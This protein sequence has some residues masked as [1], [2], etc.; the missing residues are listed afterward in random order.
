MAE[1]K[2][3]LVDQLLPHLKESKKF[4]HII[5]GPRQVGKTTAARQIAALW[6]G[7]VISV[8][9]DG[10]LPPD[11]T[12][13]EAQWNRAVSQKNC[14]LII[15]EIQ[16]VHGWSETVKALWDEAQKS[17]NNTSVLLLGSSALLVQ[18]GL[19]ESLAGRFLLHR[20]DHWGYPEMHAAFGFTLDEWIFFGGYPG[21]A[22]FRNDVHLWAQYIRDSLIETVLA[23]DV[24]QMHTVAKP[25]L[26]RHLFM[27][28]AAYPAQIVSYNKMMGQLQDAGNTTTLA[29][30]LTLLESAFIISGLEQFKTDG[31]R[32][33]GSS[34]K[35]ILRNNALVSAILNITFEQAREDH[36]LWGRLVENAVGGFLSARFQGTPNEIFYWRHRD[37]EVD[38]VIREPRKMYAVEVQTSRFEPPHGM[39]A[40]RKVCPE[41]IP[42]YIGTGG[43]PFEEFF[44]GNFGGIFGGMREP[45][46]DNSVLHR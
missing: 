46:I 40:F 11:Y 33:R 26:L 35:L 27:F 37:R 4:L 6:N 39:E 3:A 9:A 10:P 2:R 23:K 1:F 43:I 12:W 36:A 45:A 41:A 30:Y 34:P 16:K 42:V 5:I 29:H 14:L 17:E 38:F 32:K 24:L 22:H 8:A 13:L 19:T 20:C 15:D 25:A 21:A 28:A 31:P 44:R 7:P 18:K